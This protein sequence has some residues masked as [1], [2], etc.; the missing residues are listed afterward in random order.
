MKLG[1]SCATSYSVM[2]DANI[3]D[4]VTKSCRVCEVLDDFVMLLLAS[5]I[6][7]LQARAKGDVLQ[8]VLLFLWYSLDSTKPG[9]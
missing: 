4:Q 8:Y 1:V 3:S 9:T 7:A 2:G 5:P 6:S